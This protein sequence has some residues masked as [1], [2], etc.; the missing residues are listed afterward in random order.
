MPSSALLCRDVNPSGKL[1][2]SLP[3]KLAESLA[4]LFNWRER[5]GLMYGE[6]AIV[7]YRN[8]DK[9]DRVVFFPFGHGL[10]YS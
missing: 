4:Y 6:D 9:M 1:S 7:G 3:I 5:R 10:S 2:I 8:Y